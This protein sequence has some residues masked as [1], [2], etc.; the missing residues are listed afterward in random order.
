MAAALASNPAG[1]SMKMIEGQ[2][3]SST[4]MVSLL[5][6]SVDR[7]LTPGNPT[8]ADLN[9]VSSTSSITSQ[10]TS[11]ER[12]LDAPPIYPPVFLPAKTSI[13]VVLPAPLTPIKAVRTPG[14]KAPLIIL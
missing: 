7:P 2:A 9:G 5:R 6:C 10:Q 8:K 11:A 3:T 14:L 12:N 4:A 13:N 1:S